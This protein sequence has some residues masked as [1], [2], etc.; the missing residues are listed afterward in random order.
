M[1]T[2]VQC[3]YCGSYSTSKTKNGKFSDGLAKVG[4]VLGGTLLQMATGIPGILGTNVGYG[5]TWHQ[6]C[7]HDCQQVFKV[8]FGAA[9]YI[10]EI[11]K[12]DE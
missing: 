2:P 12:Y 1:S 3:P 5:Q 11:K 4:S 7:C 9:G 8:Q 10:K 6:Y